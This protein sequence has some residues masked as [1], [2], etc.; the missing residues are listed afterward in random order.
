MNQSESDLRQ[1]ICEVVEDSET[2][3]MLIIADPEAHSILRGSNH[4]LGIQI[5]S[6]F[7]PVDIVLLSK[8]EVSVVKLG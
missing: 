3:P 6:R 1:L 4:Y 7:I 2:M 5:V 8:G